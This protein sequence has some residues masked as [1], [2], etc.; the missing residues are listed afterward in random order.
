MLNFLICLICVKPKYFHWHFIKVIKITFMK[1]LKHVKSGEYL[2][3]S[4]QNLLIPVLKNYK[5]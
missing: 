1:E 2:S 5:D 3:L 4:V